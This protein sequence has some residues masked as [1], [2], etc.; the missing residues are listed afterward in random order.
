[1]SKPRPLSLRFLPEQFCR[2]LEI[3]FTDI[4]DTITQDSLLTAPAY[5]SLWKLYEHGIQVAVVT[6]RPAGWCDHIARMWPVRGVIGENGAFYFSYRRD[7]NRMERCYLISEEE[8]LEGRKKL[9]KIR[10]R[11]LRDV[12][13]CKI[14]ADQAFRITDLAIDY[15]EDVKPLKPSE[16]ARIC[17]IIEN[18]GA[19][20]KISNIHINCWYGN[21]DKVSGIKEFIK[22]ELDLQ[23]SE[24]PDQVVFIGD[25]PNDEPMF[26]ELKHCIAV[27]NIAPY[28]KQLKSLPMYLT[29]SRAAC[30]FSEAVDIILKKRKH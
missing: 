16:I 5:A 14:A 30:G 15:C 10:E 28:L 19:V 12:P 18:E 21:F 4:D 27:A 11:V 9:E 24:I 26:K 25:S 2:S 20:Y 22:N 1:M 23:L 3:L 6:G 13:A 17:R 7:K 29:K 8:R